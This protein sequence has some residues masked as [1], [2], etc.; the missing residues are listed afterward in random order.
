MKPKNKLGNSHV[1]TLRD[2]PS[3]FHNTSWKL[4]LASSEQLLEPGNRVSDA[5]CR[6]HV[7]R[8]DRQQVGLV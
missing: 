3:P 8:H 2:L 4:S 5:V 6:C 7:F 1:S